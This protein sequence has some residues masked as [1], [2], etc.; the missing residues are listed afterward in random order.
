MFYIYA[1]S[2]LLYHEILNPSKKFFN[3]VFGYFHGIMLTLGLSVGWL[4]FLVIGRIVQKT[5]KIIYYN[6]YTD[7]ITFEFFPFIIV[8]K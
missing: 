2:I 6:K 1:N 5:A 3:K 4:V 8:R 7:S